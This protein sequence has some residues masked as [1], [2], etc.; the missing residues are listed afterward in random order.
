MKNYLDLLGWQVRDMIT[1]FTGTATSISF[2]LYGCVQVL[3]HAGMDKDNKMIDQ[4]WF[5]YK[6]L[7]IIS[8]ERVMSAPNFDLPETGGDRL[9]IPTR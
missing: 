2:E 5:D 8:P 1:G 4:Q 9:P 6:R 7:A 3:I